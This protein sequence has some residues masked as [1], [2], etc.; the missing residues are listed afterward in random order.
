MN[1]VTD[2]IRSFAENSL[3]YKRFKNKKFFTLQGSS[4]SESTVW[5]VVNQVEQI[6]CNI[7]IFIKTSKLP[8]SQNRNRIK[9]V[10]LEIL[11]L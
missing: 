2:G 8:V 7:Y 11:E 1:P 5:Q 6:K 10:Q 9:I 3:D 4:T